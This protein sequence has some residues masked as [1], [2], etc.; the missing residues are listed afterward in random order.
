MVVAEEPV[1]LSGRGLVLREWA[2][3]DLPAMVRLFDE[4]EI[5]RRSPLASPFDPDAAAAYL[6]M[7]RRTRA[8]GERLHLAITTDGDTP[9][10]E[11]LLNRSRGSMGY[12]VGAAHRGHRL[13]LRAVQLMTEYA[14]RDLGLARVV[15]QIEP[16]NVASTAIAEAAGFRPAADEPEEVEGKGRRYTLLTWDHR[17]RP[18]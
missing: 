15:L 16:D 12:A 7:I 8:T 11:V 13:A 14:H 6:E 5:A 2:D 4:P 10:G 3:A 17:A 1:R 18:T 9:L